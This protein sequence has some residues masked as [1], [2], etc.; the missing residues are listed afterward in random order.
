MSVRKLA[1]E[2]GEP[3]FPNGPP[4]W[5]VADDKVASALHDIVQT[6]NWGKYDSPVLDS[7]IEKLKNTFAVEFVLPCSSG[8]IAVELA[9]RGAGVKSGDEVIIAAYDFP[10]NFRAI[11]AIGARPVLVDIA[12]NNW[13]MNLDQ[14]SQAVSPETKAILVSHLH[15]HLLHMNEAQSVA[16]RHRLVLIEDTC[17]APGSSIAGKACGSIGDSAALSFGGSKLLSAGR[18]GALLTNDNAIYQRAK[19][20]GSRG[21]EAFPLSQL[22]ARRTWTANSIAFQS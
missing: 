2:G 10:G 9:L 11:E 6:G 1:I 19:I 7:L 17:Q 4:S 12:Q 13:V 3:A 5:P 20:F 21:N 18:G 22:Q 16:S 14:I 8:T 15:G